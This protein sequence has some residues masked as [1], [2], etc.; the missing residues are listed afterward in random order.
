MDLDSTIGAAL[1]NLPQDITSMV[2]DA[3]EAQLSRELTDLLGGLKDIIPTEI[4][5]MST[6]KFLLF[7][8]AAAL[9]LGIMG[10]VFLGKRSSLNRSLSS[11]IGILAIYALSIIL[12]TYKPWSLDVLV[13][14]LPFV[15]LTGEYLVVIPFQGTA[16]TTLCSE[17]LSLVILSFLVNLLD[18]F[19][20]QGRNALGW[21]FLRL[22]TV[23]LGLLLQLMANY[24]FQTYLPGV[25]VTYAPAILL[26]LLI[27]TLL[28]GLLNLVLSVALAAVN[29]IFGAM[30][31]F[32]FGSAV[33]KQLSKAI[34]T[35]SILCCV[36]FL[37]G[38]F[39]YTLIPI[40]A[41]SLMAYGPMA[42]VLLVLWFLIGHLL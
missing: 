34:F 19:L 26:V 9:I 10:R 41:A 30:Y 25:L 39:G 29:P 40:S 32:F 23:I 21:F 24:A 31:A 28:M 15:R 22:C 13:S 36:F 12:Y 14:P 42:L 11:A 1:D 38:H 37:L 27:A 2:S 4:D 33:G 3:V 17:I 35:T 20:P 18:T 7:F 5:W 6:A 16:F 8:A